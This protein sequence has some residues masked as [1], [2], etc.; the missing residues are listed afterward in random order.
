M[1]EVRP[2]F[3]DVGKTPFM[4]Q[5]EKLKQAQAEI[6]ELKEQIKREVVPDIKDAEIARLKEVYFKACS[7]F[8]KHEVLKEKLKYSEAENK[9]LQSALDVAVDF[10]DSISIRE[11]DSQ[12]V[13]KRISVLEKIKQIR[14]KP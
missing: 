4:I 6:A 10:I 1:N 12:N 3:D 13:L 5:T 8:E 2:F 14:G 9:Q 11:L 7:D